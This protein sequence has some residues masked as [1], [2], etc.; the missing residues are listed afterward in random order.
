MSEPESQGPGAANLTPDAGAPEHGGR[1]LPAAKPPGG[2]PPAAGPEGPAAEV[3]WFEGTVN[4]LL[5]SLEVPVPLSNGGAVPPAGAPAAPAPAPAVP[6]AAPPPV[7]VAAGAPRPAAEARRP[8]LIPGDE[9]AAGGMS[10]I[11]R[12]LNQNLCHQAAMKVLRSEFNQ[13]AGARERFIEEAQIT[14]Q[15][16]HP[17]IPPVHDLWLDAN[18][19]VCFTMKLVRGRTLMDLMSEPPP[20][21]RTDQQ[22]ER[23]LQV[24]I[25]AC[26]AV[27]F[28]HSRGVIHRDLKPENVMVGTY[29][30][31]YVMDWGCALL[32]PPAPGADGVVVARDRSTRSL[33]PPGCAIGTCSYMAPEQ[34]RACPEEIDERT[35]VYLLGGILYELLTAKAPHRGKSPVHT[36]L[37][38]QSGVIE[39]PQHAAPGVKVPPGLSQIAMRALAP[40]PARR[41]ESVERLKEDV[42]RSLRHGW[43][44]ATV[45]FPAGSVIVREGDAA[46]AAYIITQGSCEAFRQEG[47]RRVVLRRMGAGEAF[48]ETA[49][50]TSQPRTASVAAVDDVVA[51]VVT[52]DALERAIGTDSWVGAFVRA[53]AE[54]FR[55]VDA[56][57]ALLRQGGGEP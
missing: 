20:E 54:R 23:L 10:R 4:L 34:A 46:D 44:F 21:R 28:A 7:P 9:I 55:E 24:F 53:L 48:G 16:D 19:Q 22:L 45:A 2:D 32:R 56:R 35:D 42:E 50:F 5:S 18:G 38:A 26:D 11:R 13:Q 6:G 36:V 51:L 1:E 14:A 15:L 8:W 37:L 30:Q 41:Y 57:L 39:D 31:V 40:E 3:P 12:V 43:W 33:D 47:D 52:R 17:N 29:G 27:A 49:I 25:K